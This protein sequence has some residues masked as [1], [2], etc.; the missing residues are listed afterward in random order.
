MGR[1]FHNLHVFADSAR[2]KASVIKAVLAHA[3]A[4]GFERVARVTAADR[5]IRIGGAAPWLTIEDDGYGI[6]GIAK[7]VAK[8]RAP[9]LE[10]YCEASAIVWLELYANA[11]RAGGWGS[12]GKRPP[13]KVVQPLL[14]KGS[15][16]DLAKAWDEGQRQVFPETALAVAAQHFGIKVDRMFGDSILRGTT[17]ALRRKRAAWSPAY[18]VGAPKF[19]VGWGSNGAWGGRHLVFEEELEDH[20]V[21]VESIGGPGR[22]LSIRFAGSAVE[23]RHI[24]IVSVEHEGLELVRDGASLTWHDPDAKVP[25][26][27]VDKPDI[28]SLGRREADKAREI[29]R[30][31]EW[32][33]D[34]KYRGIKEGACELGALVQSGKGRGQGALDLQIH[35]RPWRPATATEHTDDHRLFAMHRSEHVQAHITLRGTLAEAWRWAR[36]H[37]EAWCADQNDRGLHVLRGDDEVVHRESRHDGDALS[38]D[39]VLELLPGTRDVPF[40]AAGENFLFGTFRFKPWRMYGS[41]ELVVELVLGGSTPDASN[42]ALL[43]RL[44]AICDDAIASGHAYSA[45]V[46]QHHYRPDEKTAWEDVTATDDHPLKM[47]SWHQHHLRGIDKRMWLSA[48]HTALIDRAAVAEHATV[49]PVG[50]GLRI[51]VPDDQPRRTL[52]PLEELLRPLLPHAETIDAWKRERTNADGEPSRG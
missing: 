21:H 23:N 25:A 16:S 3:K 29:E 34:V 22:G 18:Q 37:V 38:Y 1:S 51:T 4:D 14:A 10:A 39:K 44:S 8:T 15:A 7:A 11:R 9:L 24:E 19:Y 30:K 49:T 2:T 47:I 32:Y 31:S 6:D 48:D 40:Q 45:L 46:A 5:V 35:W 12:S 20:R 36:P 17:I 28:F 52:A 50:A 27:L 43:A 42:E 41:D 33:I 26:G 13:A